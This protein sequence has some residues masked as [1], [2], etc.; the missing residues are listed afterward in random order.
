MKTKC[1]LPLVLFLSVCL[2]MGGSVAF[3]GVADLDVQD[4]T[5]AAVAYFWKGDTMKY[6]RTRT[7]LTVDDGDT[8]SSDTT[9]SE[10]FMITVRDST[11]K[12]YKMEYIPISSE[13]A[14]ASTDDVGNRM[15]AT[16]QD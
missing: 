4:S 1:I 7:V 8:L 10:E 16:L 14:E 13:F 5:I 2:G 3:H 11:A 6:I 9:F 15:M 12:G